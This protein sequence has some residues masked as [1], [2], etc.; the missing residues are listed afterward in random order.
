MALWGQWGAM[1][2]KRVGRAREQEL[3]RRLLDVFGGAFG[4]GREDEEGPEAPDQRRER[5]RRRGPEGRQ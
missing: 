1:K 4:G 2:K 5:G 3:G